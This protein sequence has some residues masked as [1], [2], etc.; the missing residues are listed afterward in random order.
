MSR[1]LKLKMIFEGI[2]RVTAPMRQIATGSKGMAK[3]LKA[4]TDELA[5]LNRAQ[6]NVTGFRKLK[7]ELADTS[8]AFKSA[9]DRVATLSRALAAAEKPTRQM[10]REFTLAKREA[11][12]L[13]TKFGEQQSSLQRLRTSLNEAGFGTSG[14]SAAQVK[15]R[16]DIGRTSAEIDQQKAKL[17]ALSER[18]AAL[19]AAK[20]AMGKTQQI[21]SNAAIGGAAA[22]GAGRAVGGPLIG[23]AQ[24]ALTFESRMID[25]KKVLNNVS[26]AQLDSI[27]DG[28]LRL[29]PQTTITA[30]GLGQI[31]AEGA[32]AGVA[33]KN[34]LAFTEGAAKMGTAF[35]MAA[36]EVG[37]MQAK[38]QTGLGLTIPQITV[39][40]D[41]VNALTNSF[42]GTASKVTE[43]ITRVGP[44]GKV[45]GV[46]SGEM[47]AMAQIMNSAGV[48]AEIGATGIKRM[49]IV[50]NTGSAAT[51]LQSAA[52]SKLGINS[53]EL[54]KRMQKDAR[55]GIL[56]VL[57]AINQ[58]PKDEQMS[59][60]TQLFGSESL[61][62]IA[63]MLSSL[64]L[65]KRNFTL[66]GDQANYAGSM[67]KE[68]GVAMSKGESQV[69]AANNAFG[70]AGISLGEGL[71]P[72]IK[73]GASWIK[74]IAIGISD[75]AQEHP[76][77]TKYIGL[78]VGAL[79]G[80]LLV[81]G[82]LAI[83]LG[84][85]LG[86]FAMLRYA[87]TLG[88]P[89]LKLLSGAFGF[90]R[91]AITLVGRAF[92]MNPI[93]LAITGI[94][95]GAYLIYSYWTPISTFF[96]GLW[97]KVKNVFSAAWTG[98]K[99]MMGGWATSMWDVG[100]NI[101]NGIVGGIKA[102]PGAVWEALK[103]VVFG[104]V[105]KIK[106]FLGF[107][108]ETPKITVGQ[109]L[110]G[111]R[112]LGG[113]VRRGLSYLVGERGPEIFTAN[114]TGSII[115]NDRLGRLAQ[116]FAV[117]SGVVALA[118]SPAYAQEAGSQGGTRRGD[119]IEITFNNARAQ[120]IPDIEAAV[121]RI[122]E[123]RDG[124]RAAY[125]RARFVDDV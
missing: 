115:P 81:I 7:G 117:G 49:M 18:Q 17:G 24:A 39:L 64:D 35:D 8:R 122:L 97:A 25:V 73:D 80:L 71:I 120:D 19:G 69:K 33:A 54:A 103:G 38:W 75:W 92:L 9:E 58:L 61:A 65:L 102:A 108:E 96:S 4:S 70:V 1:D 29:A 74:T 34:L 48:E 28:L 66:V 43:M 67:N 86:P 51:D 2:Q 31:A 125:S 82:G 90:L 85:V 30:E 16:A 114:Q 109:K 60:L 89:A 27:H 46:A 99:T 12:D 53:V 47:A 50:M 110:A 63:P 87:I 107:G 57:D 123:R 55:G 101:I 83:G 26:A 100:K 76:T 32:R 13:K 94:A 119:K 41:K 77:L 113:P 62:S 22:V 118:S 72:A 20:D 15:L 116:S 91:T 52:F 6:S 111:A 104:G 23:A 11:S 5:R 98:I 78:G 106:D 59:V 10:T 21:G 84:A 112:A 3:D 14:L 44:L 45:A 68:F 56:S 37:A 42:G 40:G 121:L 93:G 79:A 95:L 105:N 36:D 124:D 88:G